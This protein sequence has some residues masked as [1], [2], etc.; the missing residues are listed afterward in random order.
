MVNRMHTPVLYGAVIG[1]TRLGV[2]RRAFHGM[3]KYLDE[4]GVAR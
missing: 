2:L 1:S 3:K 4:E